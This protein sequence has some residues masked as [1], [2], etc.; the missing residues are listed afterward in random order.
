MIDNLLLSNPWEAKASLLATWETV[1]GLQQEVNTGLRE[2][3]PRPKLA[4]QYH[5]VLV[6]FANTLPSLLIINQVNLETVKRNL[7][8]I[9]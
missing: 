7:E 1:M 9:M 5:K 4:T 6:Y 8:H 2:N 3:A